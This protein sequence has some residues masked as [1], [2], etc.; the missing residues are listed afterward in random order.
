MKVALACSCMVFIAMTGLILA[1]NI[2][3]IIC[4]Q[5]FTGYRVD[6]HQRK[7]VRRKAKGCVDPFPYKTRKECMS[8][9]RGKANL[10]DSSPCQHGGMCLTITTQKKGRTFKCYCFHTGYYGKRCHRRCPRVPNQRSKQL[11]C[12]IIG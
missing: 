3:D 2:H 4:N 7:C 5:E 12:M 11:A 9:F 6:Y 8:D 1:E 10:C